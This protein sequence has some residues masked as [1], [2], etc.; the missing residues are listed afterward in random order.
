[1]LRVD[2]AAVDVPDTGFIR[3][4]AAFQLIDFL[5][6]HT[7]LL[8]SCLAGSET[9]Q[10]CDW[11][12]GKSVVNYQGFSSRLRCFPFDGGAGVTII[13]SKEQIKT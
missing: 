1:M 6:I 3:A 7:V 2:I 11:Q 4:E 5:L 9:R 8:T 10:I 13:H 12:M